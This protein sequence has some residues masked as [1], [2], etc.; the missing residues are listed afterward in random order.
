MQGSVL[1]QAQPG[2]DQ[3]NFSSPWKRDS[4]V[5]SISQHLD[6]RVPID[7]DQRVQDPVHRREWSGDV[8]KWGGDVREW[9]GD[10]VEWSGDIREWSGDVR[11]WSGDV[12][13]R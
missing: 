11:E 4:R 2:S 9:S 8:M 12:R 13:E 6:Y 7:L 1:S 10:I 5:L 3:H